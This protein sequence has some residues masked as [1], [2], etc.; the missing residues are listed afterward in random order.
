MQQKRYVIK[1]KGPSTDNTW[2]VVKQ[3]NVKKSAK[4]AYEEWVSTHGYDHDVVMED[5]HNQELNSN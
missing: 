4:L 1:L 5:T 3:C 2:V